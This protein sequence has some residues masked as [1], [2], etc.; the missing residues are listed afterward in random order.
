MA[1]LWHCPLITFF[2]LLPPP[3]ENLLSV[4]LLEGV[5]YK[6]KVFSFR[7]SSPRVFFWPCKNQNCQSVSLAG[8]WVPLFFLEFAK[9]FLHFSLSSPFWCPITAVT[10]T[11]QYFAI[12]SST[13]QTGKMTFF[14]TASS[15]HS[16]PWCCSVFSYFNDN[17][18]T[19]LS[20]NVVST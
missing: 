13:W 12:R 4:L 6:G 14:S 20:I 3:S 11:P 7:H 10:D 19:A 17:F 16:L 1:L 5:F 18:F 15:L 2:Q 9:G 8:L